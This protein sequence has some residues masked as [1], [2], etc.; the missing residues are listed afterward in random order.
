MNAWA[1]V[2]AKC[3]SRSKSRLAPVLPPGARAALARALFGAV[4]DSIA[5]AEALAGAV[6]VTDSDEVARCAVRAGAR[7]VRDPAGARLAAVVDAG[8]EAAARLGADAAVVCMADLACASPA[9]LAEVVDRLAAADVVAVP[10]PARAGT[11][12]LALRPP[13][14]MPSCFGHADSFERHQRSA[15]ARGLRFAELRDSALGFDVDT[16]A[17]LA[18]LCGDD[19][20]QRELRALT[21]RVKRKRSSRVRAA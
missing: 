10:D 2:P 18:A 8:V 5:R 7:V 6:V 11:S 1:V 14:A 20:L 12:V 17:D 21:G 9:G 19:A 16:P 4:I 3:F 15:R 13:R